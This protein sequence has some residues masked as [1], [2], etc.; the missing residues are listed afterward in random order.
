MRYNH[1]SSISLVLEDVGSIPL[2][3]MDSLIRAYPDSV[4]LYVDRALI[5]RER[6]DFSGAV[7]DFD[8]AVRRSR[9]EHTPWMFYMRGITHSGRGDYASAARDFA[10]LI[11]IDS[12]E[13]DGYVRFMSAH[14]YPT[15]YL[16]GI[17]KMNLG[18]Y[19]GASQVLERQAQEYNFDS[20]VY[21]RTKV[22]S[23]LLPLHDGLIW[24]YGSIH[25][26][27]GICKR[28]DG[29]LP[30]ACDAFR[31]AQAAGIEDAP[32]LL[33]SYCH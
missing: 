10:E 6:R 17:C 3:E 9:K 28:E 22:D 23:G 32:M 31:K 18:D 1:F 20:L 11:T 5:K 30:G 15:R 13:E 27:L 29:D 2:A 25:L 7:A 8:E 16:L 24:E 21:Y 14:V 33:D 26:L 12:L 4:F 19:R